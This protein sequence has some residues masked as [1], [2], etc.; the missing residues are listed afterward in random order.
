MA[1]AWSSVLLPIVEGMSHWTKYVN[2]IVKRYHAR[3]ALEVEL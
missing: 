3:V 1:L 2:W